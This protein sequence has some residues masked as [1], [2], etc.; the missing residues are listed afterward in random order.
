MHLDFSLPP[1]SGQPAIAEVLGALDD[2]I[3]AN[4]KMKETLDTM[5]RAIF[6]AW[7]VDFEPARAEMEGRWTK[8]DSMTGLPA[9]L[10]DLFP[11]EFE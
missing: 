8:G 9:E 10:W 11:N 1:L 3:E 6:K 5:T 7:F 4:N 2:K